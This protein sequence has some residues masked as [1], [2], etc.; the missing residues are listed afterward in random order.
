MHELLYDLSQ[1][2]A[3][4]DS[5]RGGRP[6]SGSSSAGGAAAAAAA[7]AALG[8]GSSRRPPASAGRGAERARAHQLRERTARPPVE[9]A[10]PLLGMPLLAPSRHAC[11]MKRKKERSTP[12]ARRALRGHSTFV[13]TRAR[14]RHAPPQR[15][16][17]Q[18]A[19][20]G[21]HRSAPAHESRPPAS[22]RGRQLPARQP[23]RPRAAQPGQLALRKVT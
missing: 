17:R 13:A 2:P 1:S 5:S 7:A 11:A 8:G 14:L 19:T 6:T 18:P 9:L 3:R 20:P 15:I 10:R 23:A 16:A 4:E 12:V 21:A 22:G